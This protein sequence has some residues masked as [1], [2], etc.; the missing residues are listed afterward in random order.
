[1]EYFYL[2]LAMTF[3]ALITVCGRLY[4]NKNRE[5]EHV[6]RL[7]SLLASISAAIGWLILWLTDFSFDAR[8][9][10][11][12]AVYGV[13]YTCFTVGMLGAIKVGSTSLTGLVKQVA[14][15][16]V[17]FWGYF[18]WDTQFTTISAIG[19]VV[20]LI[21]L[22]LCLLVKE[23]KTEDHH[24]GKWLFYALLIT[25]GNAGCGILQRYQQMHFAYQHKNMLMFFS[26]VFAICFCFVFSL[27][28]TKENWK[29]AVKQSWVFPALSG[30]SSA[31]SNL[32]ILLL[33]KCQMSPVILYPG[34]AVGGLIITTLIAF[35]GFRERLR[36]QQWVGLAVGAVALVLLN[37]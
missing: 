7:Y 17:S 26:Y 35:F 16:G 12:S 18:F 34:I 20:L 15:V 13:L 10:P 33:V 28:E 14:L 24:L 1:M 11:Y 31:G 22:A 21:S 37:L 4:N 25:M 19:I 6:T 36:P 2:L 5:L 9:L 8:V 27:G 23:K 32:F 3:S 29:R 30:I